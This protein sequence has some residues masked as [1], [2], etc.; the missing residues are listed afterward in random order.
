[1]TPE[2]PPHREIPLTLAFKPD[3][4]KSD[5]S[6]YR[7]AGYEAIAIVQPSMEEEGRIFVGINPVGKNMGVHMLP[8]DARRVRDHLSKLLL[9]PEAEPDAETALPLGGAPPLPESVQERIARAIERAK[10]SDEPTPEQ[11]LA[12]GAKKVRIPRVPLPPGPQWR[13]EWRWGKLQG[14]FARLDG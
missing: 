5:D 6:A 1:V 14:I 9:E 7:Q 8:E 11:V 4:G 3:D 10:T 2:T 13:L 12:A